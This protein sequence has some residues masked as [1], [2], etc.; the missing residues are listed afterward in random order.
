MK[1]K[2]NFIYRTIILL[3]A[4]VSAVVCVSMRLPDSRDEKVFAAETVGGIADE[5]FSSVDDN[6]IIL[7]VEKVGVKSDLDYTTPLYY[8]MNG[9][10][11]FNTMLARDGVYS[12]SADDSPDSIYYRDLTDSANNDDKYVVSE[13]EFVLLEN[14]ISD[15]S[16][17]Y[18][19]S[20]LR[21]YVASQD[22]ADGSFVQQSLTE[23]IMI[24]FG[25][26]VYVNENGTESIQKSGDTYYAG[27]TY[28]NVNAYRN[29][30]AIQNIPNVREFEDA[31]GIRYLDFVYLIPQ[32]DL[33]EGY[34]EFVFTYMYG[35]RLYTQTFSFYVLYRSS[36]TQ[37]VD[38]AGYNY[39]TTPTISCY[40]TSFNPEANNV[41]RYNLGKT[42]TNYPV[43]TYDYSRYSLTYTHTANGR[44]TRYTYSTSRSSTA[45]RE[46]ISLNCTIV[47]SN[48]N[49]RVE[50]VFT[51]QAGS[52]NYIAVIVLTE[53]GQYDFE[54]GYIYSGYTPSG[55]PAPEMNLTLESDTLVIS[56]FELMY[57]KTGYREA[58]MKY[59]T[60][61][62]PTAASGIALYLP[63][64]YL[65]DNEKSLTN[66]GVVY[67]LDTT[68]DARVGTIVA[69]QDTN[70][71]S[72]DATENATLADQLVDK[73]S[74]SQLTLSDTDADL[75]NSIEYQKTDQGSLWLTSNDTYT[76][77]ESFYYFTKTKPTVATL[78]ETNR[79]EFN[80]QT[81]FNNTGYY[82][83]FIKVDVNNMTTADYYQVFAFRYSTDTI[84]IE[85]REWYDDEAHDYVGSDKYTNEN[86][87]ISWAETGVFERDTS[88]Y[89]YSVENAYLSRNELLNTTAR[90][91][92]R[93][94]ILGEELST[95]EGASYL[96]ELRR[97]GAATTYYRFT[98]DRQAISGVT[99]YAVSTAISSNGNMI[100][101]FRTNVAGNYER[102]TS[103]ITNSNATLFWDDKAS[104]AGITV[105]Y[106]YTPFVVDNSAVG[107]ALSSTSNL[108]FS[109]RYR[110]GNTV[111]A[112]DDIGKAYSIGSEINANDVISS[113]GIY[114][115]TLTDEAGN[116]CKY[117]FVIDKT[118]A[119]FRLSSGS[120]EQFTTQTSSLYGEDVD[121]EIGTHKVVPL[122][123]SNDSTSSLRTELYDLIQAS[124]MT[125]GDRNTTFASLGYYMESDT[126]IS[127]LAN[128]FA[129]NAT[130]STYYLTV[131]NNSLNAYDSQGVYREDL[132]ISDVNIGNNSSTMHYVQEDSTSMI[133]R[134]YI[135]G[136][137]QTYTTD[138]NSVSYITVE[139]NVDNSLGTVYYSQDSF[140][141]SNVGN[142]NVHRLETGSNINGAKATSDNLLAFTWQKGVGI[143]E[144]ESVTYTY[145]SLNTNNYSPD[146]YFYTFV[147]SGDLVDTGGDDTTGFAIINQSPIDNTTDAGLYVITRTYVDSSDADYGDD[148]K[149][150][151]YYFIVDRNNIIDLNNNIGNY[152]NIGLLES[153]TY[154]NDFSIINTQT[155]NMQYIDADGTS[156]VSYTYP[157]YLETNKLPA[158]I[159]IPVGKYFDGT[160]GSEYYAGRLVFD[161]YFKDTAN[162]IYTDQRT[163]KLFTIDET[164]SA[165]SSNYINGYYRIDI[166]D[167]LGE[168][169]NS[170]KD[171]FVR[172]DNDTD[173]ICLPG[174]YIIVIRDQVESSSTQHEKVIGFRI[175]ARRP[176]VDVYAVNDVLQGLDNAV[177]VAT[178]ANATDYQY[179]LLTNQEFVKINMDRYLSD[180]TD[181]QVDLNYLVV[182]QYFNGTRSTYINY[183]YEHI[184]G[185]NL[186]NSEF[187]EN[188]LENGVVV[189]RVIR[190]DTLLRDT[191]GDI[192]Y[193]NLDK[194]LYYDV[195]VRFKLSPDA[196]SALYQNCYY[197]Y[198]NGELQAYYYS[199]YRVII[200]RQ[201][202]ENN[203]EYLLDNDQLSDFYTTDGDMFE[204]RVYDNDAG[205]FF[206]TQYRDYTDAS[207]ADSIYAFN[208]SSTTPFDNSGIYRLYYRKLSDLSNGLS[209]MPETSF[210][211][212]DRTITNLTNTTTYGGLFTNED[213]G[214]Y[215]ILELDSAGNMT[216]YV[217][218]YTGSDTSNFAGISLTYNFNIV[219]DNGEI[220]WTEYSIGA[221]SAIDYLTIFGVE[222]PIDNAINLNA[223]VYDYF[224]R[225]ELRDMT[226][227]IIGAINTNGLTRFTN[228]GL[229]LDI[230]NMILDAGQGNYTFN[231]YTRATDYSI[232]L[233]YYDEDE[234]IELNIANLVE[235]NNG[236][237]RIVL[238]GANVTS[239]GIMYYA[240]MI[241]VI[242]D[243]GDSTTYVCVP[244]TGYAYYEML[245]D[246]SLSTTPI[247]VLTGLDGTYQLIMTDAFGEVSQYRFN[248]NGNEFY[249]ISF[250]E[251]GNDDYIDISRVYYAYTQ[252]NIHYDVSLYTQ[253]SITYNIN[254]MNYIMDTTL[255]SVSY[256]E[257]TIVSIDRANG[258]I[259]IYP[260]FG[261]TSMTGLLLSVNV[262]LI[263]NGEVDYEFSVVLDTRTNSVAIRDMNSTT[264]TPAVN[265]NT[266]IEDCDYGATGTGTMYLSWTP[267]ESD[268]FTYNYILHEETAVGVFAEP[269][270]L[271]GR[272]V[273]TIATATDSLGNYR[274]EIEIYTRDG[275]YLG[276]KVYSFSILPEL[277]KLYDVRKANNEIALRNSTFNFS[278]LSTS[279]RLLIARGLGV[280]ESELPTS[281]L[282]LYIY[283]EELSVIPSPDQGALSLSVTVN[284]GTSY[285]LTVYKIYTEPDTYGGLYLATL[286]VAPSDQLVNSI[287]VDQDT[288]ST[289]QSLDYTYANAD[290][291]T[292]TLSFSQIF[293]YE[294]TMVYKNT[295]SMDVYYNDEFVANIDFATNDT[296]TYS[297]EI[298]GSG[299]YSFI[300][301]DLSGNTHSFT[302]ESGV[303]QSNLNITVLREIAVS[304]NGTS[305]IDN[306][307]YNGSVEVSVYSPAIYEQGSIEL[308]ATRNGENYNPAKSQFTYTF[309]AYGTYR[310]TIS[311]RYNINGEIITLNKVLI[312]TIINENEARQSID[313][314]TIMGY[315][316][317]SV[318]NNA[319]REILDAFREVVN[320]NQGANG[321][322][323]TYDKLIANSASLGTTSGKQMITITYLVS[324]E[325]YP[326]RSVTFS[327]TMNN[328]MPNIECSLA[329]G[330]STTKSFTITFNPGIIYSQV[331]DSILYINDETIMVINSESANELLTREFTEEEYGAG[332]YYIRL[333]SSSGNVVTSFKVEIKEPLN[334]WAIVI[335]VVVTVL[336]VG[337]V[338]TIIVLRT[339]MRIR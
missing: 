292:Y 176:S 79:R 142:S 195:T 185:Y 220:E 18:Y 300:F 170:L 16:G 209:S 178:S 187:V 222:L 6:N 252:A 173:W 107:E 46:Y 198:V 285:T 239:N 232:T 299:R 200:D 289:T 165:D 207:D 215:E 240:R 265:V 124:A 298:Q 296:H 116:S 143:F 227:E 180:S 266:D 140:G 261:D 309:S 59:L 212:Y 1:G 218:L 36:Y 201:P 119:F 39:T 284:F 206:V 169:S 197:Q 109:T 262:Q 64:G 171:I 48:N 224:Y 50:N 237:Y 101:E 27:I 194:E 269:I 33:N 221:N 322:L 196:D 229:A 174:D 333:L 146:T 238:N 78:N 332:D 208:V 339:K 317:Q 114:V 82:L 281:N 55:E 267:M 279:N 10:Q 122:F 44:T 288:L 247:S 225:F 149:S 56:G 188:T 192:I 35:E 4:L 305:P 336:V 283:N 320:V 274:F 134:F 24:S 242:A 182:Y 76:S 291:A 282:P 162:Q 83:A 133:R 323:L 179:E 26:Y 23:A 15:Q 338:T 328:E 337:V 233:N 145:Y 67:S 319:G 231:I 91:L 163:I 29:G 166:A 211:G 81:T 127:A 302:L 11:T 335:I 72:P 280:E 236:E 52:S 80:N 58:Q 112:F 303:T 301:H 287:R 234:R 144:V 99:L 315:E 118:E 177:A 17:Q 69:S 125:S 191:N 60:I 100:Y 270:D 51:T 108:W 293:G 243:S 85:V 316:V 214:L 7:S 321:L 42:S 314:T 228:A 334:A 34:Y 65:R 326:D 62:S 61:A 202:P 294:D 128:L 193:D 97:E 138:R 307:Y 157:L 276:N 131:R 137:N 84:S 308:T 38:I 136:A 96:I 40:N 164:E 57:S 244:S 115:F 132:S 160:H 216:Q 37:N 329:T 246:G 77:G 92:S 30:S 226:G 189:S 123:A 121:I 98:I 47:D 273:Y 217:V 219:A 184:A 89:Y 148:V 230:M 32:T 268:Y 327:F 117:M 88:A 168:I 95:G 199:T 235:N 150:R 13:G 71:Y 68:A 175:T 254:G 295:I 106:S 255:D 272:N 159:N 86:V 204:Y 167:Q 5:R 278:D 129:L 9:D 183:Q 126:N 241:E 249:S 306:A 154:F 156:V 286:Y 158:T 75:I 130:D 256:G 151:N 257:E 102:I 25:Q 318:T 324:D 277:N 49:T 113:Q 311:A 12:S 63:N 248:T 251:D 19:N 190:L 93:G 28:L 205:L 312:F 271:N 66:L 245:E 111:G 90:S 120:D 22:G 153:E 45:G 41:Y 172:A 313:L 263:Y 54:Y 73:I 20:S 110:L 161:I 94:D 8:D 14:D 213:I 253:F 104:G 250:G 203:I 310:V 325:I 135:L 105:T 297:Y 139:I 259:T 87:M 74:G 330:E 103:S 21:G 258:V 290:M 181:A 331:G 53:M 70:L 186:N 3:V 141:L 2:T 147:E 31:S 43:I 223:N 210:T 304:V 260:L 155:G 275:K 152:I 264:L